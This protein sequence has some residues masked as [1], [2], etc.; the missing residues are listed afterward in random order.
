MRI[1]FIL[2]FSSLIS[3]K[4]TDI[5]KSEKAMSTNDSSSN[6]TTKISS[7]SIQEGNFWQKMVMKELK[8]ANGAI[9]AV[10]PVPESWLGATLPNNMKITSGPNQPFMYTN[11]QNMQYIAQSSGMSLRQYPGVEAF[12]KQDF[13][14]WGNSQGYQYVKHYELPEVAK[15]QQW[16]QEQLYTIGRRENIAHAFGIDYKDKNGKP[17][18]LLVN[19][20]VMNMPEQQ[21]WFYSS[22]QLT[23]DSDVF[24]Q[25]KKQV[26]FS[27]AN[28]RYNLEPIMAYNRTEM[29]REGKSWAAF[30]AQ[31]AQ[32]QAAFDAQQRAHVNKSEAINNAIMSNYRN[33]N[34]TSD[35]IHSRFIDAIR[36]E[37]NV[38]NTSTGTTYKVS[39]GSNYYWMN[40]DGDYFGTQKHDYNPNLDEGVN[41]KNWEELKRIKN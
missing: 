6:N 21:N 12:V 2:L 3:C 10:T 18:F 8:D 23:V 33:N 26:I 15:P 19:I 31:L 9:T 22:Q 30:N 37:T 16:Y 20:S 32:K 36:E 17:I 24:E 7:N 39:E 14:P 11:D 1:I 4:E 38:V 27:F 13:I 34:A 35:K 29:E 25:T 41:R 28:I 5:Q 40:N